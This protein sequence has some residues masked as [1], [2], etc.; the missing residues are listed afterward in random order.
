MTS[1]DTG[2]RGLRSIFSRIGDGYERLGSWWN[3]RLPKGLY[4]RTL[5]ILLAPMIILQSVL[6]FVSA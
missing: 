4:A 6:S 3:A 5:L 1:I 2:L